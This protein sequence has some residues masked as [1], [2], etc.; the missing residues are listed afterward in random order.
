[1]PLPVGQGP[2]MIVP[3]VDSRTA[4][5]E[6][7]ILLSRTPPLHLFG[8]LAHASALGGRIAALGA[9]VMTPGLDATLRELAALR[10]GWRSDAPYVVAQH[11]KVADLIGMPQ[12]LVDAATS[13][14]P[15]ALTETHA[16]I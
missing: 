13:E 4:T 10:V 1:M 14:A 5:P 3:L 7:A 2:R 16:A 15:Q 9:A 12:T 6:Q 8:L 11:R